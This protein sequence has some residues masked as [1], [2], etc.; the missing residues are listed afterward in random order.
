MGEKQ[1]GQILRFEGGDLS[2]VGRSAHLRVSPK[3]WAAV[4]NVRLP[5]DDHCG[6]DSLVMRVGRR[7]PTAD[8][9]DLGYIGCRIVPPIRIAERRPSA[10]LGVGLS[11]IICWAIA[12]FSRRR[13]GANASI[14]MECR[15]FIVR[16]RLVTIAAMSGTLYANRSSE[17]NAPT[18]LRPAPAARSPT[19][20]ARQMSHLGQTRTY[21][22]LD[23][24]SAVLLITDST[25]TSFNVAEGP[26]T[27]I[28]CPFP[29]H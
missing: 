15:L 28:A 12:V 4:E 26:G 13:V 16:L 17:T 5:V 6:G 9:D 29:T 22:D 1:A 24:M 18:D 8:D 21:S 23:V 10:R 25:R 3:A 19:S 27:D 7:S 20:H 11:L 2:A 14:T